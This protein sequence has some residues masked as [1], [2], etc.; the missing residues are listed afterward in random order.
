MKCSAK[1]GSSVIS[2]QRQNGNTDE[3][4]IHFVWGL[5]GDFIEKVM[6]WLGFQR[7]V[8]VWQQ[9]KW[10]KC[11]PDTSKNMYYLE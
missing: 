11:V 9:R 4:K 8:T 2:V 6:S 1:T 10:W 3:K 5:L 7:S